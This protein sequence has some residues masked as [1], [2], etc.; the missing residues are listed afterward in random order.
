MKLVL[1][2]MCC[3]KVLAWFGVLWPLATS[4]LFNAIF[5]IEGAQGSHDPIEQTCRSKLCDEYQDI[6]S[7]PTGVLTHCKFTY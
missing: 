7:K 2:T 1:K 4:P 5:G 3:N 6:F